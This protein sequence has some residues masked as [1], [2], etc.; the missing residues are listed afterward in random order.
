MMWICLES[1][2]ASIADTTLVFIYDSAT[3][4][5]MRGQK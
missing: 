5:A 1:D 2:T 4:L 3:P